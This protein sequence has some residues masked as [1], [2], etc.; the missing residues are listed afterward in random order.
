MG[1]QHPSNLLW[2]Y[3]SLGWI[4]LNF[5]IA[6]EFSFMS[7]HLYRWALRHSAVLMGNFQVADWTVVCTKADTAKIVW[8]FVGDATTMIVIT[9]CLI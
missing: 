8:S 3:S 9:C 5:N 6:D 1:R 4:A 2:L 7:P